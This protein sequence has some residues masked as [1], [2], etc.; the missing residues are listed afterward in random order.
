[1]T[2]NLPIATEAVISMTPFRVQRRARWSECDPAGVVFA[3]QFPLYMLAAAHL[4][5]NHV[6]KA[7][8]GART[9]AQ[10]YGTPGKAMEMVFLGPLWPEDD[11][12]MELHVGHLG[13]R[14]TD[15]L[16]VASRS[17]D[18]ATVFVG[19]QTSIYVEAAD[20]HRSIPIPDAVRDILKRY[21]DA[22]G[23]IPEILSQVMR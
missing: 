22:A 13:N 12:I 4:F 15:M 17:D 18:S 21:Q 10:I 2:L 8:I 16:V 9:E 23:P 20:R 11:F 14:T 19:R 3:G 5:R 1:M 6:V 7:P